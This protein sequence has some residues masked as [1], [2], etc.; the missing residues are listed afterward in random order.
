MQDANLYGATAS[1]WIQ[2]EGSLQELANKL[3]SALNLKSIDVTPSEYPPYAAIGSAE[4]FGFELWLEKDLQKGDDFY[5][6]RIEAEHCVEE[7]FHGRM[8]DLSPWFARLI[9]MMSDV[10][11]ELI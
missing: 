9:H 3:A 11:T 10:H 1:I 4:A 6:L 2:F 7:A 8:H 5:K